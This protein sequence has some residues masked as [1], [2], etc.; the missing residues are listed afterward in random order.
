MRPT[1]IPLTHQKKYHTNIPF[2]K[3]QKNIDTIL[4]ACGWEKKLWINSLL[5]LVDLKFLSLDYNV[6]KVFNQK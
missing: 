5:N 6:T 3:K 2:T 1:N 4:D